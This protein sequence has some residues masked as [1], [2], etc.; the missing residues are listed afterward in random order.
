MGPVPALFDITP[1]GG[2]VRQA[3]MTCNARLT[4]GGVLQVAGSDEPAEPFADYSHL[5]NFDGGRDRDRTCDPF[6][7]NEV[8]SR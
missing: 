3:H 2:Q 8:L 1:Q 5:L 7:V 6:G 4:R